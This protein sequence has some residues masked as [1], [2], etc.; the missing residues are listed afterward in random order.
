MDDILILGATGKTGR[1]IVRRLRSAGRTVRA[2]SRTAGDITFDLNDPA[3]WT[4]AL[5][6][7]TAVYLLEPN[8]SPHPDGQ[9]PLP[10]FV[11]QAVSS[12]VLRLVLLSAY[13]VGDAGDENPLKA[14]EQA[15]RDSGAEWTILRPGWFAQNFSE[16]FWRPGILSGTLTL[17]TGDGRTAFIDAEDIAE[18]A[19]SALTDARHAGRIY[20]L[21]GPRA[22]SVGEAVELIGKATSRTIR[23]VD[24]APETFVEYQIAAGVPADAARLLTSLLVAVRDGHGAEVSDGVQQALGRPPR[25]FEDFVSEAAATGAWD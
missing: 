7:V 11:S 23:H 1:R 4:A 12:G 24:V 2:A 20:Q 6:G 8:R 22:I 9:A 14:V 10:R 18:I 13:G 16:S 17:P 21:T 19:A 5:D 25:T 15:V 3:T